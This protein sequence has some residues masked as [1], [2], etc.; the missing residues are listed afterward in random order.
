MKKNKIYILAGIG[1]L[2]FVA[3]EVMKEKPTANNQQPT[4]NNQQQTTGNQQP[5]ANN[6]KKCNAKGVNSKSLLKKIKENRIT[7]KQAE[8]FVKLSEN[9]ENINPNKIIDY[10][11]RYKR[12]W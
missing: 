3:Y 11:R 9:W 4:T 1:V 5:T 12:N 2:S 6:K 7:K 8:I 10:S